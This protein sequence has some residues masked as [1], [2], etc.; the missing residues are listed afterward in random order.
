MLALQQQ[1]ADIVMG[2]SG[3]G[4][5]RFRC[6]AG[7]GGPRP[8]HLQI[9]APC[10]ISLKPPE[11]RGGGLDRA[12][13]RPACARNLFMV[14]GIR[15]FMFRSPGRPRRRTAERFPTINIRCPRLTSISCRNGRRSSPS[16]W[17]RWRASP[18]SPVTAIPA[19]L[20][21]TLSIDRQK[22]V[23]PRGPRGRTSTNALNNAFLAASD[24]V[25]LH[26]AQTVHGGAGDRP[27]IPSRSLQSGTYFSSRGGRRH[28]G[29]T[30]GRS[31]HKARSVG[32]RGV[33]TRSRFHRP[34]CRS[35]SCLARC[36]RLRLANIQRAVEELHMPEGHSRQF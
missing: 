28:A 26:P 16:E 13:D 9:A 15:L 32:A 23:E 24:L 30:I 7:G 12:R 6:W 34:R 14:P 4:R 18:T 11:E 21:L 20:Q 2:R 27:E 5:D 19:G 22:G 36:C 8:R 10:F 3:G 17:R 35:I 29:A 33:F 25:H 1:L 31:A